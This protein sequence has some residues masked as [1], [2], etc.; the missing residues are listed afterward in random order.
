MT[1]KPA[2]GATLV[3]VGT[4]HRRARVEL[5]ERLHLT[6]YEAANFA[7]RL[8]DD[9]GEAVVLSTCN[10]T[11][12]YLAHQE[13]KAAAA[14]ARGGLA[15]LAR[16]SEVELAAA[17]SA[18]YDDAAALQLFRVAAG[19]DSLI[20]GESQILGQVRAAHEAALTLGT[21]GP[22]LNRLF[23][24]ALQGGKH[25]RSETAIG[26]QPSSV[27]AAAAQLAR[28]FYGQLEG[29]RL[30]I[31]GAGKISELA[32][33]N[34]TSNGAASLFV[35]N[36]TLV[37][38]KELARRFGGKAVRFERLAEEL[39]LA[40]VVISSTRCPRLILSA[41][42]AA[43]AIS[44][45]RGR[46]LLFIDIAVPRDL[47]PAI[48][49]LDGCHLYD[50]DDL[51]DASAERRTDR[52]RQIMKA[53]AILTGEVAKFREWRRSLGVVPTITSL[54]RLAEDIRTAELERAEG[55]L[56]ALSASQRHAVE[57][58]T[59]QIVNKLLHAPTVRMKQAALLP[60]GHA[61]VSAVEHLFGVGEN[62]R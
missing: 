7:R 59:A 54:R 44:R 2:E 50:I 38:A 1:V 47:D 9:G 51:G 31:I 42:E 21:S 13:P 19:L 53:E 25:V 41:E 34:L 20:P 43:E 32:A 39:E 61:Y 22:I 15:R 52:R 11:E 14:R 35:A 16:L 12:V 23:R 5:R 27:P 40:D 17:L 6:P 62:G 4:S 46:P 48:G 58:L 26:E 30:L 45:R 24:Q 18:A 3:L 60:D 28:R 10:R 55:R 8:A 37:R 29:R 57:A 36:R 56:G 49:Q 33:F